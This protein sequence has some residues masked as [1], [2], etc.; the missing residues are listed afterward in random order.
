VERQR[1]RER[2]RG[3]REQRREMRAAAA[4]RKTSRRARVAE[5]RIWGWA[6]SGPVRLGFVFLSLFF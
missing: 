6:P 1:G 5:A 4:A 2:D 3:E